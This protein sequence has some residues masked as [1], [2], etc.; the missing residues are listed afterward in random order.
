MCIGRYTHVI[1][2]TYHQRTTFVPCHSIQERSEDR[3]W[4]EFSPILFLTSHFASGANIGIIDAS[5]Q[6]WLL[7]VGSRMTWRPQAYMASP[8]RHRAI[9]PTLRN[10]LRKIFLSPFHMVLMEPRCLEKW[11]K[12]VNTL[13]MVSRS[14]Y[15]P[16]SETIPH[17]ALHCVICHILNT[18][19][20]SVVFSRN[21][22]TVVNE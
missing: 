11:F 4:G 17:Y 21:S 19:V 7:K 20:P 5:C 6:I 2:H 3:F 13:M 16:H 1:A 14:H 8:F 9:L 18:L 15:R 22:H 10:D 12:V